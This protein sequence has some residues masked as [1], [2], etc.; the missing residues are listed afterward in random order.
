VVGKGVLG[1][2]LGRKEFKGDVLYSV[3]VFVE[4]K[5][6]NPSRLACPYSKHTQN[7]AKL[8]TAKKKTLL[9]YEM[10]SN[11]NDHDNGETEEKNGT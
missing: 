3:T 10:M 6:S 7:S 11:H 8:K 9:K 2:A 5:E 4:R 1:G